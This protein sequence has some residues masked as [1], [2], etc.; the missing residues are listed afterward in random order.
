ML[1]ELP[2]F[3]RLIASNEA[4]TLQTLWLAL[5]QRAPMSRVKPAFHLE[6][7]WLEYGMYVSVAGVVVLGLAAILVWGRRETPLKIIGLLFVVLGLGSFHAAA[8][9]RLLH[10]HVPFFASEH[11]PT[12]F[13]Y[14]ALL[15]L[16]LVAASGVGRLVASRP[17]LDAIAA[18]LV[19]LMAL[20]VA[21]VS[22][23]AMTGSMGLTA[24]PIVP[25]DTFHHGQRSSFHYKPGEWA[26]PM[27][28]PM[29]ANQG[30]IGCYGTPDLAQVGALAVSDARFQGEAFVAAADSPVDAA[31]VATARVAEWSPNRVTLAFDEARAGSTVVY[32]MNY[33]DGWR[34]DDGP[35]ADVGGRV[36]VTLA[37]PTNAVTLRYR[38]RLLVPGLLMALGALA[39]LFALFH[40][41]RRLLA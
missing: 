4:D 5:T 36:A 17:W 21:F 31:P 38:P 22:R 24:P 1:H 3:R 34:A 41:E 14:P 23:A 12:R 30:V 26:T 39:V 20:D 33:D 8:P 37:R 6:Y 19:L 29:L 15:L 18:T 2:R 28:L 27:Y 9:W 11:V 32:N 35:V 13:W 25:E 40:R 10:D 16:L 7:R